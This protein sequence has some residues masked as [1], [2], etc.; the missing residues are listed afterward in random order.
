MLQ[1]LEDAQIGDFLTRWHRG[2]YEEARDGDA[3]HELLA[4]AIA[5]SAAVRAAQT[6]RAGDLIASGALQASVGRSKAALRAFQ[7]AR[8][9][10]LLSGQ[11]DVG[12]DRKRHLPAQDRIDV[13][14]GRMDR[15]LRLAEDRWYTA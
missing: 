15:Q 11:R 3:K 1:E 7:R 13:S 12:A 5:D 8:E 14:R 4:R 10:E 2:A 6:H 9:I